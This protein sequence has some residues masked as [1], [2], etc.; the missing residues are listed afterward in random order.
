MLDHFRDDG[1]GTFERSRIVTVFIRV[2][3]F[4]IWRKPDLEVV[5][6]VVNIPHGYVELLLSCTEVRIYVLVE[7]SHVIVFVNARKRVRGRHVDT[8]EVVR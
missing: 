8:A 2:I 4:I 5:V 3:P 1:K 7:D 6:C